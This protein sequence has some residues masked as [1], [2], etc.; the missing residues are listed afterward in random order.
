MKFALIWTEQGRMN[1][2]EISEAAKTSQINSRQ[3]GLLKQVKKTLKLLTSNPRHPGLNIHHYSGYSN[4][5]SSNKPVWEAYVQNKAPSAYR[6][7]WC[8]GPEKQQI[9]IL[10]ITPHP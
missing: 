3:A 4:P 6:I 5:Y 8:F 10:A 1:Y 9:T 7:F 2:D